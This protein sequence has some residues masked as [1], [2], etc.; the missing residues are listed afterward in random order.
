METLGSS[1]SSYMGISIDLYRRRA[2]DPSRGL[3]L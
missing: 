2:V 3:F 1:S